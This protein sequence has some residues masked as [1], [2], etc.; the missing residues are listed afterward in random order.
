MFILLCYV[1]FLLPFQTRHAPIQRRR[2]Y[3]FIPCQHSCHR[4]RAKPAWVR[5][6]IQRM[7]AWMPE[8]SSRNLAN[9]FNRRFTARGMTIGKTT[10]A[11]WLRKDRYYILQLRR[12][13][14]QRKPWP[15]RK[16]AVWGVDM[17]G[18]RDAQGVTH[19]ILGC[20]DHGSRRCFVL[21]VL[22]NKSAWTLLGYLFLAIGQFGKPRAIRTDNEACFTSRVFTTVL[23]LTGIRHQR[24]ALGCPWQNGRIERFFGTLKQKLNAI[25]PV[26]KE[27]LQGLLGEFRFWY[28]AVRPHQNLDA[29]TPQEAWDG[30]DPWSTPV[31]EERFFTG[32]DGMLTGYYLRR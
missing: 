13:M 1:L 17:T 6:E 8:S 15:L 7:K 28:D 5:R 14:K 32:W 18:K 29:A 20:V 19:A 4:T 26:S 21:E 24:S 22:P 25:R 27:A 31:Q 30:I 9:I 11:E 12:E 2:R 16:N 23:W 10:V 3:P